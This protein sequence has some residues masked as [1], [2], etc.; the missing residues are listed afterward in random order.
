[1]QSTV[2]TWMQTEGIIVLMWAAVS[3]VLVELERLI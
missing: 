3:A 2:W 1:M